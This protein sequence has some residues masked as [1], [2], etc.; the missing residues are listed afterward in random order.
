MSDYLDFIPVPTAARH[1]GWTPDRQRGFITA[2]AQHGGVA[3]AARAV[4]MTPQT[5]RRLRKRA[6]AEGFARA[7]DLAAEEG[8]MRSLDEAIRHMDEGAWFSTAADEFYAALTQRRSTLLTVRDNAVG[9]FDQAISGMP[10]M[11][12][13]TSWY[14]RWRNL[15]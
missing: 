3:A 2:L 5:A 9:E 6:G 13:S 11:V 10:E 8:R 7:W 1:D 15:G 12:D 4:G 14:V